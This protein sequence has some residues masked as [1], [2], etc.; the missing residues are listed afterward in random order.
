MSF[1]RRRRAVVVDPGADEYIQLAELSAAPSV[2]PV[3]GAVWFEESAL[4]T[5]RSGLKYAEDESTN[6]VIPDYDTGTFTPNLRHAT[7]DVTL[8]DADGAWVRVGNLVTVTCHIV[9][10]AD[11]TSGM[12]NALNVDNMPFSKLTSISTLAL[13]VGQWQQFTSGGKVQMGMRFT[14]SSPQ[15]NFIWCNVTGADVANVTAAESDA[16]GT[17]VIGFSVTYPIAPLT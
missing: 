15:V 8:T 6:R 13:P 2:T 5:S 10:T 12:T 9:W 4:A 11:I 1:K 3:T 16:A 14:S 17:K 7:T